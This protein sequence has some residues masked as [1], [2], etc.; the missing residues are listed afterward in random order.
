MTVSQLFDAVSGEGPAPASHL[1]RPVKHRDQWPA[2]VLQGA[3]CD[4][5][6]HLPP[7]CRVD[8]SA[9][10]QSREH[11]RFTG[12]APVPGTWGLRAR[13]ASRGFR[14]QS[15]CQCQCQCQVA[16]GVSGA[17][18]ASREFR[19]LWGITAPRATSSG[20]L[21]KPGANSGER[22]HLGTSANVGDWR[23]GGASA[24]GGAKAKCWAE[25]KESG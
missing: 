5:P 8:R 14:C 20:D 18:S 23:N 25:R 2:P 7:A 21:R 13:S 9:P 6:E 16:C 12:P 24:G 19:R 22:A 17:G 1:L 11:V 4:A 15:R 10:H 3:S